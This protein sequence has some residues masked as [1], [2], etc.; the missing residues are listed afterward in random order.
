MPF[1]G[2][3]LL[4]VI[5][6]GC[7][8]SSATSE[9]GLSGTIEIDG[10]STVYPI[11]EAVAEEFR[12]IH[13]QVRINV[14]ISGT[15]GGFKRFV[16]GE[17][18]ISDASRPIKDSEKA[19]ADSNEVE[20]VEMPVAYDGLSVMVNPQNTWVTSM[21]VAEL[22]KLWEP[23]STIRRWNQIRPEW[24]DQPINLYGPGTDSGTFEYFTEAIVGTA[25]SSRPDYTASEDDNVLVQGISGDR[26]ALGYFGFAYY[27][28]N[29]GKLKLVAIDAGR[30][31][32]L[33]SK[34]TIEDGTYAP[35]SRP[36]FIYLNKA[37]LAR[38]EVKEFVRFY[39]TEGPELVTEVGYV[40]MSPQTYSSNLAKIQ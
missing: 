12:K 36:I 21:T 26:N 5:I 13:P 16:G 30:G 2:I 17:T 39:M 9:N 7:A 35:L 1:V 14:G 25:R 20:W 40:P 27:V 8:R 18:Q 33:P 24:P 4:A 37:A 6:T 19:Q 22:K 29:Q 11:T 3:T 34:Q 23:N 32:V 15:G 38:P 10:S 31:A 28:E